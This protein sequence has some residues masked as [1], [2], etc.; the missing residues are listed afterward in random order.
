[1]KTLEFEALSV[2]KHKFGA[3]LNWRDGEVTST[4]LNHDE[5][6][7]LIE[8]L[9]AKSP[10]D[11][12]VGF[13]VPLFDAELDVSVQTSRGTVAAKALD[14]SLTGILLE[15]P[16]QS[17]EPDKHCTVTLSLNDHSVILSATPIRTEEKL[18]AIHFPTTV[19]GGEL[20]PPD[21]LVSIYRSLEL[22]W[23][24]SRQAD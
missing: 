7:T 20:D 23:L 5:L 8:F 11:R 14:L 9:Q 24:K 1:M 2:T 16:E 22:A 13:R 19:R 3:S 15:V 21:E 6:Q 4:T 10:S 18:A 17:L 12:R